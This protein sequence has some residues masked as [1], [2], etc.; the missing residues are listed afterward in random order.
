LTLRDDTDLE[1]DNSAGLGLTAKERAEDRKEH[2][3][4]IKG[5]K[6]KGARPRRGEV[7]GRVPPRPTTVICTRCEWRAC[8]PIEC[9]PAGRVIVQSRRS[10]NPRW[11]AMWTGAVGGV[12]VGLRQIK[13]VYRLVY[14]VPNTPPRR[15]LHYIS[16]EA[17]D[18]P[19]LKWRHLILSRR[20]AGWA[21]SRDSVP[22]R[23]CTWLVVQATW[24]NICREG[25]KGCLP[26]FTRYLWLKETAPPPEVSPAVE[27]F[28]E[29]LC[30]VW[31]SIAQA[32]DHAKNSTRLRKA[33]AKLAEN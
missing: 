11:V 5:Q 27:A 18:V 20:S 17:T 21:G 32:E 4:R 24:A 1:N 10:A 14:D 8:P 30:D 26:W 2:V 28:Y 22:T 3:A 25:L 29:Q 19:I 33:F 23:E 15:F 31:R 9:P 13:V 7:F 16:A 6:G 12:W